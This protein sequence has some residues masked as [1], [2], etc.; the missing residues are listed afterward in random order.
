MRA[1]REPPEACRSGA[2][3]RKPQDRQFDHQTDHQAVGRGRKS[4][5]TDGQDS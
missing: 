5:D 4:T 1:N 2:A 3:A